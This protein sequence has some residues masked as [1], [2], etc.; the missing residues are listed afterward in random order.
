VGA[1]QRQDGRLVAAADLADAPVWVRPPAVCRSERAIELGRRLAVQLGH[2]AAVAFPPDVHALG[3]DVQVD[4]RE[5]PVEPA[6]PRRS[7]ARS[8]GLRPGVALAAAAGGVQV[9]V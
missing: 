4:A 8:G 5:V 7:L 6:T 3:L 2:G 1:D 9:R